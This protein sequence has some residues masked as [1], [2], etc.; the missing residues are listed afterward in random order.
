MNV[1]KKLSK[2]IKKILNYISALNK[3]EVNNISD[4]YV[5]KEE[6]K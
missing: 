5:D 4:L 1:I 2:V 6:E 3:E